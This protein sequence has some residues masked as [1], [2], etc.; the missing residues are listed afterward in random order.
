[1]D[2]S[3]KIVATGIVSPEGP[4]A[5]LSG[6]VFLVS[7]WT[8]RVVKVDPQG[9]VT[10]VV[11]TG[12]KP[13]SVAL[14][15]TGELLLADAKN[16]ALHKI[17]PAGSLS[18]VAETI[19]GQRFIGPND[20]VIADGRIVYLT[21]PGLDMQGPGRILRIELDTGRTDLLADGFRFPNGITISADGRW[22]YVA[23]SVTHRVLR[24][25]LLDDGK[26][27]GPAELFYQF[28]DHHPDGIAFDADGNLLVTLCGGG[29]LDI[30]SPD[31][32]LVASIPTG[33][34][35]CTNIVFGGADFRTLYLTEDKQEA[36]L[37]T[38]WPVPGQRRYS[39]SQP[40]SSSLDPSERQGS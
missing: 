18:T 3:W 4:A 16:H 7:R 34:T 19:G 14:L 28:A 39:R 27:L 33:G 24:F 8:G 9:Q 2:V 6:N 36:L 21:D 30:V 17:S 23:E 29:T 11:P 25:E 10:E 26:R 12:G 37:A 15:E 32:Q 31:R 40:A 35:D 5:D 13:Q 22:L 38:R 20:L 1:M